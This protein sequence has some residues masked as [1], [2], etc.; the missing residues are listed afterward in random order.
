MK[1]LN[2]LILLFFA[3]ISIYSAP[4]SSNSLSESQSA[5]AQQNKIDAL[6]VFINLSI[7]SG[8]GNCTRLISDL[9]PCSPIYKTL[10]EFMAHF[11]EEELD[12][13]ESLND[14]AIEK[15]QSLFL[16]RS[17]TPEILNI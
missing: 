7:T 2:H 1:Q 10:E 16:N 11:P 3:L 15:I 8:S 5:A 6:S 12:L 4:S 9:K 14:F 13:E 17:I